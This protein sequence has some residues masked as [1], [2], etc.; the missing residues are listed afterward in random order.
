MKVLEESVSINVLSKL[1]T[2][3]KMF[4]SY[5]IDCL[6]QASQSSQEQV[7]FSHQKEN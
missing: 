6:F 1:N 2:E 4:Y 3:Q 5:F 7:S